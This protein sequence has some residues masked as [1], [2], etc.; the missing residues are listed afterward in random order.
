MSRMQKM[1]LFL[2]KHKVLFLMLL[3]GLCF[4]IKRTTPYVVADAY[5]FMSDEQ[6]VIGLTETYET[7]INFTSKD[8][9]G[10]NLMIKEPFNYFEAHI[11]VTEKDTGYKIFN[12][13][14]GVNIYSP[15]H[16]NNSI[17]GD[18]GAYL[19]LG[20]ERFTLRDLAWPN[21]FFHCDSI[22]F[23]L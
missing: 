18:M 1:G 7:D 17:A 10:F 22:R 21:P 14:Y 5:H 3:V 13:Q 23:G 12:Q 8:W 11:T 15:K 20:I 9:Y 19:L 6:I 2:I 16:W 4:S